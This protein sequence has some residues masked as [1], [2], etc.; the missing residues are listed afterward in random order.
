[1]L[2][3]DEIERYQRQMLLPEWGAAGQERVR[4]ARVE[5]RGEGYA[6]EVARRY[7]VGAGV[8]AVTMAASTSPEA[9][10]VLVEGKPVVMA[11]DRADVDRVALGA[12]CAVEA[13]KALL[14]LSHRAEV[15]LPAAAPLAKPAGVAP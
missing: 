10:A 9:L 15:A 8:G 14:G 3:L 5:V 4:A 6:A 2:S 1:M 13:L 12:A 11:R 7:L